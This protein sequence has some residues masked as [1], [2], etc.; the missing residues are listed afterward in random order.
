MAKRFGPLLVLAISISCWGCGDSSST[1]GCPEGQV[2][3]DGQC[4]AADVVGD[5]LDQSADLPEDAADLGAETSPD[6][7]DDSQDTEAPLDRDGDGVADSADNCPLTANP[8]QADADGDGIGDACEV[9]ETDSDGDGVADGSDNCP[10]IANADQADADGDGVGDACEDQPDDRDSDGVADGDDNCPDVANTD[11]SDFDGDGQGDACEA[12]LGTLEAPIIIPVQGNRFEYVDSRDTNQAT[13]DAID[14]YPPSAADESGP[15]FIYVFRLT[16]RMSLDAWLNAEP[17]GVDID[18]HLLSSLSPVTLI[19]RDNIHITAELEPGDYAFVADTYVSGTP[20]MGPYILNMSFN[21]YFAGTAQDP[22][23]VGEGVGAISPIPSV[24]TDYRDTSDAQSDAFDTYPP[25]TANESGPEFVYT[26]T[27]DQPARVF[28]EVAAPEPEGV[29]IDVHLLSSLEPLTLIERDD[30]GVYAELQPG[31]YYV[32]LDSYA[33]RVGEYTFDLTLRPL[34]LNDDELFNDYILMAVQDL[35]DNYGLLGYDNVA[36]THDLQYGDQGLLEAMAPPRTMCV[37]A[38][39]EVI[40]RAMQLYA[41]NT[42][43]DSVFD[44]L[45]RI[46]WANLASSSIRAHIWVNYEINSRGTGD[47]LRHFGMGMTVPFEQLKPGSFVNLNRTTGSGHAVVFLAFIDIE[48]N[49]YSTH[50]DD[51]I[52]FKYFS[53]QGGYTDGGFDYRYAVFSEYGTPTMPYKRDSNVIYSEDQLYLNTGVLYH[54]SQWLESSWQRG[55]RS[56]GEEIYSVFD[57]DYFI[58]DF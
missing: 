16:Q 50:N 10:N 49:E 57:A 31:T 5:A 35:Y 58:G 24:F 30:K 23:P 4:V 2:E 27:I 3:A 40:I 1:H 19:E 26:F 12:Q 9:V 29:D 8:D 13:S 34:A 28:A 25:N 6:L 22:I 39:M 42:G 38:T 52:G 53:S 20:L 43:D 7:I 51:I 15:E 36:L 33:D 41:E 44:H 46:S 32:V 37:A 55:Q 11:Q 21:A 48:G 18:I 14:A 56:R 45:P 17:S 47:A 54:P